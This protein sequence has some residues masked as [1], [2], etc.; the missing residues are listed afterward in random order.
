MSE[1]NFERDPNLI[2][3]YTI[4]ACSKPLVAGEVLMIPPYRF[5]VRRQLTEEEFEQGF[6]ASRTLPSVETGTIAM[7]NYIATKQVSF[8]GR[9][10]PDCCFYYRADYI[11]K[12]Q[13]N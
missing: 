8:G 2:P 10:D 13:E 1:V 5:V 9:P 3:T 11:G 12:M 7:R 4:L 6:K